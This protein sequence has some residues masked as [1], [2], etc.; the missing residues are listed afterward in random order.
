MHVSFYTLGRE[1]QQYP[2]IFKSFNQNMS[3]ASSQELPSGWVAGGISGLVQIQAY[4]YEFFCKSTQNAPQWSF[5]FQIASSGVS[6]DFSNEM[7]LPW[8]VLAYQIPKL[9]EVLKQFTLSTQ[10]NVPQSFS[11]QFWGWGIVSKCFQS[12]HFLIYHSSP[13]AA[14]PFLLHLQ[15][16]APAFLSPP[17]PLACSR[18]CVCLKPKASFPGWALRI[19][20]MKS[21]CAVPLCKDKVGFSWHLMAWNVYSPVHKDKALMQCSQALCCNFIIGQWGKE[22][23]SD[24][25]ADRQTLWKFVCIYAHI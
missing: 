5:S 1:Q 11:S 6:L 25:Q 9:L 15:S 23:E 7:L 2:L 8:N 17:F 21:F 22:R 10:T 20:M 14:F 3:E 12:C 18:I 13:L 24:R 19:S 16:P 4:L